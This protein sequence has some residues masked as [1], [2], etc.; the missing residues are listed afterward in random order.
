MLKLSSTENR[1]FVVSVYILI[2]Y[3]PH[4]ANIIV[5]LSSYRL[6][7]QTIVCCQIIPPVKLLKIW[8]PFILG[9]FFFEKFPIALLAHYLGVDDYVQI[10]Y[11]L[12]VSAAHSILITK[13]LTFDMVR[14]TYEIYTLDYNLL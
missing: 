3:P 6:N 13:L 4:F 9:V 1:P 5:Q 8:Y 10:I 7:I 11:K 2:F 12:D 14:H